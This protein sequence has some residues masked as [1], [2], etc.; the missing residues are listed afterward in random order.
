MANDLTQFLAQEES[1]GGTDP[2]ARRVNSLGTGKYQISRVLYKDIQKA[3]PEFKKISYEK[4]TLEEGL[5]K[6]TAAAGIQV[7]QKQIA[8]K[9]NVAPTPTL[10][11]TAWQQGVGNLKK[12]FDKQ[13]KKGGGTLQ[14]D[15]IGQRRLNRGMEQLRD[16]IGGR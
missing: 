14:L 16:P 15:P 5:D 9:L 10:I 8:M 11:A 12:A 6:K 4:A 2:R 13:L 7:I 3:F 1:S